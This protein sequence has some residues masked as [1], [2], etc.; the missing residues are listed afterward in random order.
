MSSDRNDP[1]TEQKTE[2][3]EKRKRQRE[4]AIVLGLALVF[5]LLTSVEFRLS[6]ISATLPFVNSIFFFGLINFNIVILVALLWL[7]FKN[8]G[9]IFFERKRQV[10]GARLKTKLVTAFIGFSIVPTLILFSISALYINTSFDKW[11]SLKIQNTLQSSLEITS[12]YYKNA[13][14]TSAHFADLIAR[15]IRS[16]A[17]SGR[18]S[19]NKQ[20]LTQLEPLRSTYNLNAVE[21]YSDPLEEPL[22]VMDPESRI[23]NPS[24]YV[25]L[26]LDR[27]KTAFQGT[28]FAFIQNIG[29]ADLVRAIAPIIDYTSG[30]IRAI[31]IVNTLIPVSLTSRAGQ[32]AHTAEDYKDINPLKYPIKTTYFIILILITLLI[33]FA[34]TWLGL[35]IAREMTVPVERLVKAAQE[36]GRG[37]LDVEIEKTGTDEIAV[38]VE[39]FNRMTADLRIGQSTLR[40]RTQQLEAILS[41]I[42]TGVIL[43]DETGKI[44]TINSAALNLLELQQ[45]DYQGIPMQSLFAGSPFKE[46]LGA[47]QAGLED[48]ARN[49]RERGWAS[50]I[51]GEVHNLAAITTPLKE[52]GK[53]WGAV[54]VLD[55]LT[56][57]VKGQREMAW[58]E[59]AKRIAHEIKN[60]LTPIKLSAQRLQRRLKELPGKDGQLVQ[61]LTTTIIQHTDELK[62]MANEFGNFARFP[63][64]TPYPNQLNDIIHE[65]MQIYLSAH[66]ELHFITRLEP[67]LPVFNLDKDQM[68]RVII[69][70]I[71]NAIAA[72]KMKE[73]SGPGR[74][75]LETH[76]NEK[77]EVAALSIRDNGPG[78]TEQVQDRA[79]EPYFSTKKEGTGLGLAIVKRIINDHGGYIRVSSTLGEGTTFMIELPTK[80]IKLV[81]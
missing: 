29:H 77:L 78:M 52:R 79:F 75:E 6:K 11:F 14:T 25:R 42:A 32:I 70:L 80:S 21:I 45:S 2:L 49:E 41:N 19:R 50:K 74:V 4:R 53:I 69:N 3:R 64:V 57:L 10:L 39:S 17:L 67:R 35:Y 36:V 76:Y 13:E 31:V 73:R 9:K 26:S 66:P 7:I 55:D 23:N 61:E 34:E 43:V 56:Y 48:K 59:V 51:K 81:S 33:I 44:L 16:T 71:D 1:T 65:T 27:L 58:R 24:A 20:L 37:R 22:I 15:Q 72:I 60:P 30:Q 38:L 28:R 5:A 68:K 12:L 62:E 18:S 63:E 54:A 8:V 47:L 40:Q 46:L